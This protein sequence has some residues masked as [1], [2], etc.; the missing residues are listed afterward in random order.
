M[1]TDKY[2]RKGK[3]QT[4]EM[5]TLVRFGKK[6]RELREKLEI[7]Q[8]ALAER[9]DMTQA[10][11]SRLENGHIDPTVTKMQALAKALRTPLSSLLGVL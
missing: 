4:G 7:D 9:I 11:V 6:V 3:P 8:D 2:H 5:P 1:T 10:W